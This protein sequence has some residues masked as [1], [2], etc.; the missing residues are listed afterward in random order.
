MLEPRRRSSGMALATPRRQGFLPGTTASRDFSLLPQCKWRVAAVWAK[1]DAR[2]NATSRGIRVNKKARTRLIVATG[3]IVVAFVVG[4]VYLVSQQGAYYKQVSE[5]VSGEWDGKNVEVG[6]RVLDGTISRDDEGVTF[7]IQD[8][9]GASD[10]VEVAYSGQMPNTF[11]AGV[12]VVVIGQYSAA[13]GRIAADEL[14]TKCPSKYEGQG[15]TPTAPA[16]VQ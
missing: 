5:L 13:E 4:V 10:T 15:T 6:G 9:S 8:L 2:A 3:V 11:E 16:A 14:Q 1:L 7:T 12:D